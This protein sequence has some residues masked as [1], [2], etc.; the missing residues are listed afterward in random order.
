M[1]GGEGLVGLLALPVRAHQQL[2]QPH[3]A[4]EDGTRFGEPF[5]PEHAADALLVLGEQR[6]ER[7]LAHDEGAHGG[8]AVAVQVVHVPEVA[9]HLVERAARL[10]EVVAAYDLAEQGPD[11]VERRLDPA[12]E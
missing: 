9:R 3:D 1:A 8:R 2:A 7:L 11:A 5:R 4:A 6:S 10:D 12:V